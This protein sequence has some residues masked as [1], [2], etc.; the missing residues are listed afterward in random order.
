M[1]KKKKMENRHPYTN[2]LVLFVVMI[3]VALAFVVVFRDK[4]EVPAV[5]VPV[6]DYSLETASSET[7]EEFTAETIDQYISLVIDGGEQYVAAQAPAEG[8]AAMTDEEGNA[9][10]YAPEGSTAEVYLWTTERAEDADMDMFYFEV[11]TM[12]TGEETTTVYGPFT[13]DLETLF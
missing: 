6:V 5:D 9:I 3:F 12:N 7:N 8:Y 10:N 1:A 11:K 2:E 4:N 13:N